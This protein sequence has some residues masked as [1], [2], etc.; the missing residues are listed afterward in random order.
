MENGKRPKFNVGDIGP[1]Q[2]HM[3]KHGTG[4]GENDPDVTL[5]YTIGVVSPNSCLTVN[6][7]KLFEVGS[8]FLVQKG[9]TIIA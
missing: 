4:N 9:S 7:A 8:E 2:G 3:M 5:S 1:M 6:L